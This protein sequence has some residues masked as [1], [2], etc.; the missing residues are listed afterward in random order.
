MWHTSPLLK[1]VSFEEFKEW[2]LPYRTY[3]EAI[4]EDKEQL[5][6]LL[7]RYLNKDGMEDIY[8]PLECY[9]KR[10]DL[11]KKLNARITKKK[12]VGAFELYLP[13]IDIDCHNLSIYTCNFLRACGIPI[14]FEFTPQWPAE[15]LGHYWCSSP[16]SNHILQPY[17][18]PYNN[19]REDWELSLRNAGKV[20]QINYGISPESPYF[21]RK[22]NELIPPSLNYPCIKD[23]TDRYHTCVDITVPLPAS[24]ENNLAYL[25]FFRYGGENPVAWGNVNHATHTVTFEKVPLNMFFIPAFVEKDKLRPFGSP[26]L[27]RKDSFTNKVVK[28]TFVCD[29]QRH[30]DMFLLRKYPP[31]P[32]LVHFM[33][34]IKNSCLIAADKEEGPYDTLFVLKDIIPPYW[35]EYRLHNS[36]KYR[37]YWFR[38]RPGISI[39]ISEFEFLGKRVASHK[40]SD[41]TPLPVFSLKEDNI[42][43]CK[44]DLV[45]IEGVPLQPSSLYMRSYDNNPETYSES[46]Y[47]G[48]D[49]KTPVCITHIRLLPRNAMNT[50]ELGCHYQLLYY[51]D[52]SWVEY[53]TKIAHY[54]FIDFSDV[55]AG[56]VYWLRNLDKG[57]EELPFFYLDGKQVFI[58]EF[59]N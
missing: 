7:C 12:P 36:R 54:N 33:K 26:F 58:N 25:C 47:L 20:Y 57:K 53:K 3:D 6:K 28:D 24:C 2:I 44:D 21:I 38:T 14:V 18:P 50:I 11:Y 10:I 4:I 42:K 41:P 19:L 30:T 9:K 45:K 27:M 56:T 51:K 29:S 43:R 16:D 52:N 22:E 32:Y 31:K 37:F 23:V 17:T 40:Y 5:N 13:D 35:T 49:F 34:Q 39:N 46:P 1:N 8:K 59:M 15:N 48:M 55:P